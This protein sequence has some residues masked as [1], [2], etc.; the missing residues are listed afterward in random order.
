MNTIFDPGNLKKYVALNLRMI[1]ENDFF[2]DQ[3]M[4]QMFSV[5]HLF[6]I[7]VGCCCALLFRKWEEHVH[8]LKIFIYESEY[9]LYEDKYALLIGQFINRQLWT[10]NLR[11]KI[12][13][14]EWRLWNSYAIV[15]YM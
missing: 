12:V 13:D 7:S 6:Y 4:E 2:L 14:A 15:T 11:L 1:V 5:F 8:E 3:W 9:V 10:Q